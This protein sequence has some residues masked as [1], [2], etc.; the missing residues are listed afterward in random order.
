MKRLQDEIQV[1]LT[2]DHGYPRSLS[3]SKSKKSAG[4]LVKL[5]RTDVPSGGI[6]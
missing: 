1:E 2:E 5:S 6:S 4:T 3:Q